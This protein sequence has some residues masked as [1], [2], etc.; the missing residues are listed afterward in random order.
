M[1]SLKLFATIGAA[2][3]A[4]VAA[5]TSTTYAWHPKGTIVKYVQNTTTQSALEDANTENAAV[6]ANTGDTLKYVIKISNTGAADSRGYNDMAYT[7]LKDTLPA[8]LEL[9]SDPSQRQIT[10]NLGTIKP[11]KSVTREY[12]VKVTSEVDKDIITNQACF[13]GN[14]TVNDNPQQGC[15]VAVVKVHVPEKPVTPPVTPPTTPTTPKTPEAPKAL[16]NAGAGSF[17]VPAVVVSALGY[18]GFLTYL[19]RRALQN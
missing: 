14:S 19:K 15:D 16:P 10:E 5:T 1:K 11:G 9:I 13:T 6:A 7:V 17:I 12:A 3:L 18:A 2:S 8:G 4:I